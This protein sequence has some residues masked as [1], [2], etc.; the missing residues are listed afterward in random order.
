[1]KNFF[2][3]LVIILFYSSIISSQEYFN[4]NFNIY[5]KDNNQSISDVAVSIVGT[6]FIT[7]SDE[8]GRIKI[9]K[10]PIRLKSHKLLLS[11][12]RYKDTFLLLNKKIKKVYLKNR[13]HLLSEVEIT[14]YKNNKKEELEALKIIKK[15]LKKLDS[16]LYSFSNSLFGNYTY[17]NIIENKNDTLRFSKGV[18]N[19]ALPPFLNAYQIS[20]RSKYTVQIDEDNRIQ[21]LQKILGQQAKVDQ[22]LPLPYDLEYISFI[23]LSRNMQNNYPLS[24]QKIKDYNYLI[25]DTVLIDSVSYFKINYTPK[26]FGKYKYNGYLLVNVEDYGIKEINSNLIFSKKNTDITVISGVKENKK[27]L[28]PFNQNNVTIVFKKENKKYRILEVNVQFSFNIISKKDNINS[29]RFLIRY[30]ID[31]FCKG[32]IEISSLIKKK[33][34]SI[35][36]INRILSK[37][38]SKLQKN[39]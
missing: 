8:L 16:N 15:S 30:H 12:L 29:D 17:L 24:S 33:E 4:I 2:P 9:S 25:A 35:S 22:L 28:Y 34:R 31:N 13:N 11:S 32:P 7:I 39:I 36:K 1:M 6:D 23:M 20:K 5:D 26:S 3:L 14:Y 10:I 21:L 27:I 37:E 38:I 18:S 19:F